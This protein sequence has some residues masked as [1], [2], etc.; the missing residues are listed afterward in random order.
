MGISADA[1]K[2]SGASVSSQLFHVNNMHVSCKDEM[3]DMAGHSEEVSLHCPQMPEL[4]LVPQ[5]PDVAPLLVPPGQ[6]PAGRRKA[7]R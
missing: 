1:K 7:T 3:T 4:P 6:N 2:K 5:R